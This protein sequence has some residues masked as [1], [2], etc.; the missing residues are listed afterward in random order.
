VAGPF[1]LDLYFYYIGLDK[2]TMPTILIIEVVVM[3]AV[4]GYFPRV[5]A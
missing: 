1:S 5:R 2:T 3:Q 4:A